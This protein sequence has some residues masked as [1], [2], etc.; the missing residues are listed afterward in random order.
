MMKLVAKSSLL[1]AFALFFT[2]CEKDQNTDSSPKAV[3]QS[4]STMDLKIPNGFNFETTES[5]SLDL[6]I[7][8]APLNARY[9]LKVY[10]EN[11]SVVASPI[12][13]AFMSNGASLN[14]GLTIPAG[15]Q[16][17]YLVMQAP[18]GSSFLTIVPKSETIS[19]TFYRSKNKAQVESF[20]SPDCVSGCDHSQTHSNWWEANIEDDVYCV[21]GSYNGSGGITVKNGAILR[22]CGSGSIPNITLN[23]GQIQI[24][25]GANVTVNNFNI[26]TR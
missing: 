18:D 24:V 21:T 14:T 1:I 20:G 7:D 4:S 22:L 11:P 26:L 6:N 12:Y 13:Q 19:H 9:L 2:S 10:T 25:A 17:L 8:Q 23:K 16:Q 5:I 15:L 3:G